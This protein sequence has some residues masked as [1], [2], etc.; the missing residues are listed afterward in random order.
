[1][2]TTTTTQQRRQGND[3]VSGVSDNRNDGAGRSAAALQTNVNATRLRFSATQTD[4]VE[5]FG[6]F[7]VSVQHK[8]MV[9]DAELSL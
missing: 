6:L 4:Q 9:E 7:A 5:I 2:T 1:M 3:N 8:R